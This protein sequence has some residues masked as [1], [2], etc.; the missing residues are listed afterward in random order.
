MQIDKYRREVEEA[1]MVAQEK[2]DLLERVRQEGH[3][4]TEKVCWQYI[5]I[6]IFVIYHFE[7]KKF[8]QNNIECYNFISFR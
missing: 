8:L 6:Y 2:E 4:E 7:I 3:I 1:R 5:Y